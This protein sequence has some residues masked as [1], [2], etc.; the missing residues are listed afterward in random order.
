MRK[1][2]LAAAML[3]LATL[4]AYAY[5]Q[6]QARMEDEAN[7][8]TPSPYARALPPTTDARVQRLRERCDWEF[9][10]FAREIERTRPT[11]REDA[12]SEALMMIRLHASLTDEVLQRSID[13]HQN[14]RSPGANQA[15]GACV[16]RAILAGRADTPTQAELDREREQERA[17]Q[18]AEAQRLAALADC[19]AERLTRNA[20]GQAICGEQD[21]RLNPHVL[22]EE[23]QGLSPQLQQRPHDEAEG[24]EETESAESEDPDPFANLPRRNA[25]SGADMLADSINQQG[26][27]N[28]QTAAQQSNSG[29]N[30]GGGSSGGRGSGGG[31]GGDGQGLLTAFRVGLGVYAASEGV[32]ANTV[33]QIMGV[34][35]S[36]AGSNAGGGSGANT[37]GPGGS[38]SGSAPSTAGAPSFGGSNCDEALQRQNDGFDNWPRRPSTQVQNYQFILAYMSAR[39]DI[40]NRMCD[41]RYYQARDNFQATYDGTMRTC[42]QTTTDQS[43]CRAAMP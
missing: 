20:E 39:I 38:P 36:G 32:D 21:Y 24:N 33:A 14:A 19:P 26:R 9:H 3:V 28:R 18:E 37:G 11:T 29:R 25:S 15:L 40:I 5:A 6:P 17:R 34:S 27:T 31:G 30:T 43:V 35:P 13:Q 22:T 41:S 8:S 12:E 10:V 2:S 42:Q 1:T 7:A 4:G 16:A 23:E